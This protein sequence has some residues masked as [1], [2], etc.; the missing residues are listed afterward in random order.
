MGIHFIGS[1]NLQAE[2]GVTLS[3]EH[4]CKGYAT[5]AII[6]IVDYL[7]NNLKKHRIIASVD[8]RNIK[9][10]ALLERIQMRKEVHFKKSF[11]FNNEWADDVVYVILKG[12]WTNQKAKSN[13][14]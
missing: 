12:E 9:S 6:S 7:F 3:L 8:P 2:I 10:I 1:D 13:N 14:G 5:E 4:Q 11:W